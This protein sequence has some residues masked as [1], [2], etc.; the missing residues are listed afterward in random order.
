MAECHDLFQQFHEKIKLHD[1]KKDSLQTARDGIRNRIE[2]YF[3]EELKQKIPNFKM[4]GSFAMKT[5]VNPLNGEYDV[6]DGVYLNNIETEKW[7]TPAAVH[8]WIYDAVDGH[9]NENPVDKRTCVRVKYA[10]NYHVDLPIYGTSE[11]LP[12]LAEKFDSGWHI[13]DPC[14]LKDW[15]IDQVQ[16]QGEQLRYIVRYIKAWADFDSQSHGECSSSIILTVLA[17]GCFYPYMNR[18]DASFARTL[19]NIRDS[20]CTLFRVKNPIDESEIISD[21]LTNAQKDLFKN[22]INAAVSGASKALQTNSNKEGC[23]E[24]RILLGNRF[25]NC[26]LIEENTV[27]LK[28]IAPAILHDD[29]RSA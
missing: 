1:S 29:A 5:T 22:R 10:N 15:F 23:K 20:V 26:D 25:P 13:S 6:D 16:T 27:A 28:T 7:P 21:R 18:D 8:K 12:Y 17:T 4:Q 14:K 11:D 3:K 19:N 2:K 9:T 24:W